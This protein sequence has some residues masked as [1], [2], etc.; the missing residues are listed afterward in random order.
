[1]RWVN[2]RVILARGASAGTDPPYGVGSA[3]GSMAK[4]ESLWLS[5]WEKCPGRAFSRKGASPRDR[6]CPFT[7]CRQATNYALRRG[8]RCSTAFNNDRDGQAVR[9]GDAAKDAGAWRPRPIA[10]TTAVP[11][12]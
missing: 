4:Q 5:R 1:M 2:P 3:T 6:E 11:G 9:K 12:G 10:M 7:S 8:A